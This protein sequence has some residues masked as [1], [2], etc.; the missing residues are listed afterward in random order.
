MRK[1]W[2]GSLHHLARKMDQVAKSCSASMGTP[3]S[4]KN[5]QYAAQYGYR[6]VPAIMALGDTAGGNWGLNW[7]AGLAERR[8][9]RFSE[10]PVLENKVEID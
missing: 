6:R 2:G 10:G 7:Q 9:S 5:K 1:V 4:H 3:Y 8:S